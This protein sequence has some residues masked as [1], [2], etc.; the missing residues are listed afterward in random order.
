MKQTATYRLLCVAC[1]TLL[2]GVGILLVDVPQV[3]AQNV[4][5]QQLT[6]QKRARADYLRNQIKGSR[7]IRKRISQR[8]YAVKR[9][10][11]HY[12][13]GTPRYAECTQKLRNLKYNYNAFKR[14]E[15]VWT[16]EYRSIVDW[17]RRPPG[18]YVAVGGGSG[19]DGHAGQGSGGGSSGAGG[20]GGS[21]GGG[22]KCTAGGGLNL[23]CVNPN[24]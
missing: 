21:G 11:T 8:F 5:M 2:L 16:A 4:D 3:T 17:L 15:G 13:P 12:S 19:G 10:R 18:G 9:E 24:K 14:R 22:N 23:L 1:L 20:Y 6:A 7:E